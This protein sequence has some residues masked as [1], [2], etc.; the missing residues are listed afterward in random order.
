MATFMSVPEPD[1]VEHE[2]STVLV[3]P[4]EIVPANVKVQENFPAGT[5]SALTVKPAE[6][7]LITS[8]SSPLT[9]PSA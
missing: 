1:G 9:M 4:E 3:A 8:P 5:E 2:R 6:E 7:K